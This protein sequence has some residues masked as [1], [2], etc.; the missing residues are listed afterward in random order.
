MTWTVDVSQTVIGH[1][2]LSTMGSHSE[3]SSWQA[4]EVLYGPHSTASYSPDAGITA[5][6][7]PA[8]QPVQPGPCIALSFKT[9]QT[10]WTPT[11]P[12]LQ[13]GAAII[14]TG[15]DLFSR[16]GF[17]FPGGRAMCITLS[18]TL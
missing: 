13:K 9:N 10:L 14:L 4:R 17:A 7:C 6:E 18:D 12:Q 11:P 3:F 8:Y 1:L 5:A 2:I 16:Y 15:I